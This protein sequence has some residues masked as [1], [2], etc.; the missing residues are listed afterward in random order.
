MLTSAIVELQSFKNCRVLDEF[1]G[2][3]DRMSSV[4]VVSR[5]QL[6]L[7]QRVPNSNYIFGSG[8]SDSINAHGLT[9]GPGG[10]YDSGVICMSSRAIT[11]A[12]Q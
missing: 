4:R 5:C 9:G 11:Y 7:P 8:F 12:E 2:I 3:Q 10:H 1:C 6:F